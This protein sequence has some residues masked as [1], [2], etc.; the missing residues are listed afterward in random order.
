MTLN[1]NNNFSTTEDLNSQLSNLEQQL[2]SF[3]VVDRQGIMRGRVQDIYYDSD[4]N[5]NLLFELDNTNSKLNLR[6]LDR[7][8]ICRLDVDS[9]LVMSNLSNQ[10][11]E[12]LPLYQPVSAHIKNALEQSSEYNDCEM[13]PNVNSSQE[14]SSSA[15][16]KISLLEE[17]LKVIR[18]KQ[19]VGEIVVRKHVET[20]VVE[21]PI[22]REKLIVE[23]VGKNTEQLTEIVINEEKINGLGYDALEPNENPLLAAKSKYFTV[24]KAQNV[25]EA[26]SHLPSGKNAKIRLEIISS[27]SSIQQDF[28]DVCDRN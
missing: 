5:I 21:I 2:I 26:I 17:K 4:E 11:L 18:R 3:K 15:I 12:N 14:S 23:R 8:D 27:D 1:N 13:N 22:R 6:S 7:K 16:S 19:K 20:K 28:Q 24:E 10:Q 9:K 25:L